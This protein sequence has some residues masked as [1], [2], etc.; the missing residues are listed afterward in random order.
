MA[1]NPQRVEP[2]RL[3]FHRLSNARRDDAI[4]DARVHPREL[5]AGNTGRKEP[6]AIHP[7]PEAR[8][9]GVALDDARDCRFK[10]LSLRAGQDI[11]TAS[12]DLQPLQT[13]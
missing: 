7:D 1:G 8:A 11:G 6:V 9:S 13:T 12:R 10:D 2:E 3:N 5:L 4:A